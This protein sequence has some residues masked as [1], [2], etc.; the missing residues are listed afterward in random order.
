MST[1]NYEID[2]AVY[3]SW[4]EIQKTLSVI[5]VALELE[6]LLYLHLLRYP[7]AYLLQAVAVLPKRWGMHL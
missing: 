7:L 3:S 5:C 4:G 1:A 6:L 2:G